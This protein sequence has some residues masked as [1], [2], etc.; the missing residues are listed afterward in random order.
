MTLH[1]YPDLEQRSDQWLALRCG[2][3][4]ASVVRELVTTKARGA[5]DFACP[6]CGAIALEPCRSKRTGAPI[7]TLHPERIAI[8]KA[9]DSPP[10]L[11]LAD[12]E[13]TRAL[14]A[15]L[16]AER[17]AGV[18][19]DGTFVNRDMF[20]GVMAEA[21]AREKYAEHYGTEVTECG[22][23]VLEEDGCS[24]GY[25][26]DGLVG[27]DGLV[28]IKAPRQKGHLLTAV[29][30]TVPAE[31][32]AQIQTGLLVSG[33]KWCDFVSYSGGMRMWVARVTPDPDW[34]AAIR[35]AVSEFEKAI[36]QMVSDYLAAVEG[37]PMT[38]RL[39]LEVV[40]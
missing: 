17:I 2:M 14:A 4:T 3:V 13:T 25:S 15:F 31:H 9:D 33:R 11:V 18:D 34:F 40:I 1:E 39:D 30:G 35:R 7:A 23:L 27:G 6:P 29:S 24:I 12:N 16:A 19:P 5:V 38:E 20:R 10:V 32:I 28:E 36:E 26:P 22:F 37:F 8:A 21:P